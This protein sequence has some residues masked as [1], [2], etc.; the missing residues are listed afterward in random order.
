M[1]HK[2]TLDRIRERK[3]TRAELIRVRENARRL[4]AGGDQDAHFVIDA[5]EQATPTDQ[6]IVFMGFCPGVNF[7]NRLDI[8]WRSDGM[9]TFIFHESP[10]Q[11]ER[12]AGIRVGDLVVLKKR[13]HFAKTMQLY[14]HGR[15]TGI[16]FDS[17]NHR[18]LTMN[19]SKQENVIEVPLMGCNS[20]VDVRSVEAVYDDM[21]DYFYDW[22]KVDRAKTSL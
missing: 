1:K 20:T 11:V 5:I 14:G 18:Y 2:K 16:R 4:L 21:P 15:V 3:Y 7:E 9:C 22:L 17:E 19:W 10:Q 13:H 8:A 6:Y 12:F